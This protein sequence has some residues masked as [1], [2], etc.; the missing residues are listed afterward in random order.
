MTGRASPCYLK[1]LDLLARRS[2]FRRELARKLALREFPGEEIEETCERL[3]GE[4]LLDD[5]ECARQ[6]ASGSLRRK[7]YG[8]LRVRAELGRKGAPEGVVDRVVE[9]SFR[10][11][12][13]ELAKGLALSWLSRREPDRSRLARHLE[14]KGYPA[15]TIARV[16]AD[17]DVRA[18]G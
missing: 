14:R 5:L 10:Q 2:H 8:P 12:L 13:F 4:G 7:G 3:T 15:G 6:F 17:D 18:V 1:A 9:E 11:G 16:L